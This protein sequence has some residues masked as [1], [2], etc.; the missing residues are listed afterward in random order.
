MSSLMT[1]LT[2]TM[3]PIA[4]FTSIEILD[5]LNSDD[6]LIITCSNLT[7]HCRMCQI[8]LHIFMSLKYGVVFL[9]AMAKS[10]KFE[11]LLMAVFTQFQIWLSIPTV[12]VENPRIYLFSL[13]QLE[14]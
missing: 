1:I 4:I 6:L 3:Y 13:L 9:T 7:K 8:P 14:A 5:R 10:S 11:K 2:Y 12:I